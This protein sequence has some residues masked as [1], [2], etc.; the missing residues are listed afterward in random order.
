MK[1]RAKQ[2]DK[3]CLINS[4]GGHLWIVNY[5]DKSVTGDAPTTAQLAIQHL[6]GMSGDR[7]TAQGAGQAPE[8]VTRGAALRRH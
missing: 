8:L 6:P 7:G 2:D 5:F 3:T 4:E 1:Q